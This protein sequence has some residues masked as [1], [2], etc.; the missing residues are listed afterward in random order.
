MWLIFW[1]RN[2]I[3]TWNY[4]SCK[5]RRRLL[6]IPS[7]ILLKNNPWSQIVDQ[8]YRN[9]CK[10]IKLCIKQRKP[11]ISQ[12]HY[13]LLVVPNTNLIIIRIVYCLPYILIIFLV[14]LPFSTQEQGSLWSSS[15][16]EARLHIT[17][18][19]VVS[20]QYKHL[21][22]SC[23]QLIRRD[24]TYFTVHEITWAAFSLNSLFYQ[25]LKAI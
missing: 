17:S 16:V 6:W 21:S 3:Q 22:Q 14:L 5:W 23:S 20:L 9:K 10:R 15:E 8:I 13:W 2:I 25:S 1:Q 4:W 7:C 12:D 11:I 18:K 19:A 24:S